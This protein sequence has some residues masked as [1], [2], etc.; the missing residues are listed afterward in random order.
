MLPAP[1]GIILNGP[2]LENRTFF[3]SKEGLHHVLNQMKEYESN[4]YESS[5]F[6]TLK[7][8][9]DTSFLSHFL[10]QFRFT[11]FPIFLLKRG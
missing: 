1:R 9:K 4:L 6:F 3:I 11:K 7:Y 10:E 8:I 2:P 5:T